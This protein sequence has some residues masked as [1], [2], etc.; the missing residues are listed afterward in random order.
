MEIIK[1]M[2]PQIKWEKSEQNG[3]VIEMYGRV[4]CMPDCFFRQD[5]ADYGFYRHIERNGIS[6]RVCVGWSL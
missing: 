2:F 1:R 5:D 6:Y 3:D 4:D